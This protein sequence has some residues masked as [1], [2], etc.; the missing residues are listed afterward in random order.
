LHFSSVCKERDMLDQFLLGRW[1]QTD[2]W[3][4]EQNKRNR[5]QKRLRAAVLEALEPRVLLSVTPVITSLDDSVMDGMAIHVRGTDSSFDG[6]APQSLSFDW[7]F[8]DVVNGQAAPHNHMNGFNAAH[9]YDAP[10][11]YTI[12]LKITDPADNVVTATHQV[13]VTAD[14]R[15]KIFVDAEGN[16]VNDGSSE[17]LAVATVGRAQQL[18][19]AHG[20]DTEILFERG[21][22]FSL[23]LSDY[24]SIDDANILV[25]AYGT[26]ERPRFNWQSQGGRC[27]SWGATPPT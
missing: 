12:T 1:W 25:G 22:V 3:T 24:L 6:N 17:A 11:T 2:R 4:K 27:S 14:T 15:Q 26:G 16:D 9:V 20:D 21:D 5:T 13:T 7:N 18:L 19:A 10:G 23:S 8:G